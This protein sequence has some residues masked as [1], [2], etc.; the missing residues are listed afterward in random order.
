MCGKHKEKTGWPTALKRI[1]KYGII[2][3]TNHLLKEHTQYSVDTHLVRQNFVRPA[4][5]AVVSK[6]LEIVLDCLGS[7]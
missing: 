5:L 6:V 3:T 2:Q 7:D 4:L 1:I